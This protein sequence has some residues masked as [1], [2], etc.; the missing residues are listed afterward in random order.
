MN[1]TALKSRQIAALYVKTDGPYYGLEGVDPWD[2]ERDARLYAGPWPV[3]AHPPCARWC[4]L[5]GFVQAVSGYK[6]G[7][8]DG[9]FASALASVRTWGGVLE[10]PAWTKAW[11]AFGLP[12]PPPTG[13]QR[14][15]FGPGWVCC[16]WQRHYG[17]RAAKPTWLYY[18]GTSAPRELAW[19]SAEGLIGISWADGKRGV[20]RMGKRERSA[21]PAAFRDVLLELAKGAR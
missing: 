12:A 10:H 1:K 3:V 4:L 11:A 9:M 14:E 17:H 16:V 8:D 13:W 6:V 18:V 19:G 7:D 15:M 21:T 5:A 2:E 20:E